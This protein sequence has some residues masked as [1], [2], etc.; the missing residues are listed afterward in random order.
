[1]SFTVAEGRQEILDQLSAG[2]EMLASAVAALT[3]AYERLDEQ[4]AD[5]LEEQL[6]RP[7][8]LAYGRARRTYNEFAER[9]GLPRASFAERSPGPE[10]QDA[11]AMIERAAEAV[12]G[13]DAAIAGLQDSMLPVEVGD[14]ELRAGLSET[15]ALIDHVPA[16][17]HRFVRTVGR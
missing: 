6:F 3:G 12:E 8:Q 7:V 2:I 10:R 16:L 5:A 4:R 9:S 17:A 1:M 14:Q 15:R 11:I 13:A